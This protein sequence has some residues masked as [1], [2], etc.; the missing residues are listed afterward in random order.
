MDPFH[1]FKRFE[2]TL[3]D[4]NSEEA[5]M[6]RGLLR[7]AVFVGPKETDEECNQGA[8]KATGQQEHQ[9]SGS[10]NALVCPSCIQDDEGAFPR[11]KD[12]V[13][14][15]I[16]QAVHCVVFQVLER[17]SLCHDIFHDL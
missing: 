2:K 7:R 4:N 1:W 13:H 9:E 15:K 6:F 5:A 16:P 8:V 17:S 3:E 10:E 11:V 14:Y 12:D